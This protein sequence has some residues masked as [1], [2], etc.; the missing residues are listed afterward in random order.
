MESRAE[1]EPVAGA[2]ETNWAPVKGPRIRLMC[3]YGGGIPLWDEEGGL[4]EDP[5]YLE[6]ELGLSRE[7]VADL[8]AWSREWD[9]RGSDRVSW[10]SQRD[11]HD[12]V[13]RRLLHRVR[14]EI[15]PGFTVE[16][17]L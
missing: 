16:L 6:R 2:G 10:Q 17:K 7:L 11:R 4:S 1:G 3:D 8:I 12:E 5:E 13:G 9:I 14:D 15:L